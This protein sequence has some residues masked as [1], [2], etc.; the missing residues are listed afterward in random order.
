M[1]WGYAREYNV[2]RFSH[3]PIPYCCCC[4]IKNAARF[5]F[6]TEIIIFLL[7]GIDSLLAIFFYHDYFIPILFTLLTVIVIICGLIGY[8]GVNSE[9]PKKLL[10]YLITKSCQVI[11]LIGIIAYSSWLLY[12]YFNYFDE[13]GELLE[14]Y[15]TTTTTTT[16]PT[17]IPVTLAVAEGK[18]EPFGSVF[19][20]LPLI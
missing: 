1:S 12:K 8:F 3:D 4:R 6:I 9:T 2:T 10:P 15:R 11:L 20:H 19:P 14:K 13:S 5:V 7:I 18:R 17:T 16:L